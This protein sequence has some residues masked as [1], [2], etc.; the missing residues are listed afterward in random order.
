MSDRE[1]SRLVAQMRSEGRTAAFEAMT[2]HKRTAIPLNVP[3]LALLGTALGARGFKPAWA[4]L[5][6]AVAWWALLRICDANVHTIGPVVAVLVPWS[7]LVVA[8]IVAWW[9]WP[10]G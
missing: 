3:L 6:T 4:A 7:G 10:E 5:V 9:R 2:L 8:T 1:L